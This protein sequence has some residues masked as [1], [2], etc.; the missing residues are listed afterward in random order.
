MYS[1]IYF[2]IFKTFIFLYHIE[3]LLWFAFVKETHHSNQIKKFKAN[4]YEI[5]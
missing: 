1:I 3:K 4:A 2:E 5:L